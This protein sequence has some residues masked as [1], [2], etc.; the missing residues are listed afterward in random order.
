M[1]IE[2]TI[3]VRTHP[4]YVDFVKHIMGDEKTDRIFASESEPIGML[5]KNLLRLPPLKPQKVTYHPEEFIEFT[6]PTYND[7][8][9]MYRNYISE[10]AEKIIAAKI[11]KRFYYELHEFVVEMN[12]VGITE[13]RKAI[14]LF[15][16]QFEI[17]E[18]HYK[19][20]TL[21]RDY[22]RSRDKQK[23]VKKR[24]KIASSFA[25]IL[26]LTTPHFVLFAQNL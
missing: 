11:R 14:I 12:R 22:R 1:P 13:V 18:D 23:Y 21:E 16:E 10:T 9:T 25:A 26:S 24:I 7:V 6:L 15:C 3:R 17:N 8:N 4:M 5:I 20:N 19:L 2:M